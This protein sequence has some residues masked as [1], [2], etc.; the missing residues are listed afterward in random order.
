MTI[1]VFIGIDVACAQGKRLPI[2]VVDA[3]LRPLAIP[4]H[5]A[6]L[7]PRGLGNREVASE[8][9][10][11][12]AAHSVV[13]A[14]D[15]ILDELDWKVERIAID[16]PA[17][18]PLTGLRLADGEL[19]RRGLPYFRTPA[20]ENWSVIRSKCRSHLASGASLASLPF[21][22][23]LWMLFGFELFTSFRNKLGVEV[24]EVYPFAIVRALL[25]DCE[26]KST[27]AGYGRQLEAVAA[28]TGWQPQALE[29]ALRLAVAGN[30]HDRLDSFM[31]AWVAS[32]PRETRLAYGDGEQADDAIWVPL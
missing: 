17:A 26:H 19:G 24:I 5:L 3:C 28:R 20:V 27:A 14:V 21:G 23:M 11:R 4:G 6:A 25:P 32:L 16:A 30:R 13:A 15:H 22:R 10:F 12:E 2:C 8:F 7:V 29:T 1:S 31:A 18:P 9:A